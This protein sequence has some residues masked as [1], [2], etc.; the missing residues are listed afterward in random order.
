MV[1]LTAKSRGFTLVELIVTLTIL[2]IVSGGIFG[3]IASGAAGYV[4]SRNR[5]ALQSGARFAVERVARELRHAVPNSLTVTSNA[6][7]LTYWPIVY[8]GIYADREDGTNQLEVAISAI[9]KPWQS[10]I[11][12]G[13]HRIVFAP[14]KSQDLTTAASNS[15]AITGVSGSTLTT[16]KVAS[17]DWPVGSPSS[18]FYLYRH[19]VTFCFDGTALTRRVNDGSSAAVTLV[20]NLSSGSRFAI[21]SEPLSGGNL[22]RIFYRFVQSGEISEYDQQVQVLNAP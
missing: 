8:T 19:S 6:Q 7:C 5:D 18:R 4:E 15:Y 9:D 1:L 13:K 20:N 17:D 14:S 12:D 11:N 2:A 22:V 10:Q 3:F 21:A 16:S